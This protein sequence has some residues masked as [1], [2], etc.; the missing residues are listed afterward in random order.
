MVGLG[1]VTCS[2]LELEVV[3]RTRWIVSFSQ[4]LHLTIGTVGK[5]NSP[6]EISVLFLSRQNN[7]NNKF[8]K[9][10][11]FSFGTFPQKEKFGEAGTRQS[12]DMLRH[13]RATNERGAYNGCWC[14]R[15]DQ[16]SV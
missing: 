5:I 6:K 3:R 15:Q 4:P 11:M 2:F 14:V 12:V 1:L 10:Q 7:N 13:K 16:K 9:I 8:L